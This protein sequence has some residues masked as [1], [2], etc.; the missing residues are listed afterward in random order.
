MPKS[1]KQ[2]RAA[3]KKK[4]QLERQSGAF[5]IEALF[6]ASLK[7]QAGEKRTSEVLAGKNAGGVYFAASWS[8]YS[9]KFTEYLAGR[10]VEAYKAKGLEIVYVSSNDDSWDE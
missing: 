4:A 6:G 9:R 7:T 1:K 3:A 8:A 2:L 10:Y 5:A